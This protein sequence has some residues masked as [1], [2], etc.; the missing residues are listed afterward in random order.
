MFFTLAI[1]YNDTTYT[2]HLKEKY[3]YSNMND[4]KLLREYILTI[5]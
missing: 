5:T 3:T 2:I 4:R 1:H